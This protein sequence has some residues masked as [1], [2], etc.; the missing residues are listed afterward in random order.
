MA[1]LVQV[2][3]PMLSGGWGSGE[4]GLLDL[5]VPSA[6]FNP[7]C[8]AI[9]VWAIAVSRRWLRCHEAKT[10]SR[11]EHRSI[12]ERRLGI[13]PPV[14]SASFPAILPRRPPRPQRWTRCPR[15]YWP[16]TTASRHTLHIQSTRC[17][18]PPVAFPVPRN[19][20]PLTTTVLHIRATEQAMEHRS[21][22]SST[23]RTGT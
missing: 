4:P 16:P 8:A 19:A 10:L 11:S 9:T 14:A 23:A 1:P 21:E 15:R 5:A 7:D 3:P 2:S 22:R 13:P 18:S 6:R 20:L 12:G 17:Y